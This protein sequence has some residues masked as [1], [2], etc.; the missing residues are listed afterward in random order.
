MLLTIPSHDYST[1]AHASIGQHLL[2]GEIGS[3]VSYRPPFDDWYVSAS[4]SHVFSEHPL[5]VNIDHWKAELEAGYFL[6]PNFA[7]RALLLVKQGNG[8]SFPRDFVTPEL[9]ETHDKLIKNNFVEAGVGFDWFLDGGRRVS[10]TAIRMIHS[11]DTH[12]LKYGFL[13][14]VGQSF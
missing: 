1:H 4:G 3:T 6:A 14:T 2:R 5:G 13:L 9:F 12:I 11:E 8:L 10:G 7:A